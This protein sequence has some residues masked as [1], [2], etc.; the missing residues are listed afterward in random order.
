MKLLLLL[1]SISFVA[2]AQIDSV[3]LIQETKAFQEELTQE[4]KNRKT[5]PLTPADFKK[6]KHHDFYPIDLTYAVVAHITL[7]P[8][9]DFAPMKASNKIIQEYRTYGMASFT[10]DGQAFVL[11]MYQSKSLL[12]NPEYTDYLFVPFTDLTTGVET[13]GGGRYLGLRIPK[14]GN[15]LLINF[16]L[17][18]NPYCAYNNAY[19]CPL[20]PEENNLPIAIRAGVKMEH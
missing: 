2:Q 14:E 18:Y 4:F 7:T 5:S 3:L 13:Y 15:E 9:S 6:F 16:N 1:F 12:K 8:E 11:P 17:A 20:V 19:S 10:M